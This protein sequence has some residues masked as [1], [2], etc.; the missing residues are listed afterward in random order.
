[1]VQD[2]KLMKSSWCTYFLILHIFLLIHHG[3]K[4]SFWRCFCQII[5]ILTFWSAISHSR[6]ENVIFWRKHNLFIF[7]FQTKVY[8]CRMTRKQILMHVFLI[9]SIFLAHFVQFTLE[10]ISKYSWHFNQV[11]TYWKQWI[12]AKKIKKFRTGIFRMTK[13]RRKWPEIWNCNISRIFWDFSK[14][15]KLFGKF[16][17]K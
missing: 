4:I 8:L 9:I 10:K 7:L 16:M 14:I 17:K 12:W 13:K 15:S 1:M 2:W 6:V 5:Q 3:L 11:C